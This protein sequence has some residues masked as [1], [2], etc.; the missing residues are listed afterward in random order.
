MHP[1]AKPEQSSNAK[2]W[3][4]LGGLVGGMEGG[5]REDQSTLLRLLRDA[6]LDGYFWP[7][8]E[9][10]IALNNQAGRGFYTYVD[11]P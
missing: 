1:E 8:H 7:S 9:N 5:T 4:D 10:E 11:R 6:N 2:I 3:A